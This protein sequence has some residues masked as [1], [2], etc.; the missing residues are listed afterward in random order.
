MKSTLVMLGATVLTLSCLQPS[1]GAAMCGAAPESDLA[2]PAAT[3][4][5]GRVVATTNASRYTYVQIDTGTAK[6]WA[7]GPAVAVKVGDCVSVAATMPNQNFYSPT[8]KKNFDELY[9][10]EAIKLLGGA[11]TNGAIGTCANGVNAKG[12]DCSGACGKGG[13]CGGGCTNSGAVCACSSKAPAVPAGQPG[14]VAADAA[15]S[16]NAMFKGIQKPAGGKTVAEVW[17]EK[18]TLAGKQVTVQARVV[19]MVPNIMGK[20]FLHLRDGTGRE[21]ANDLVVTTKD[22]VKV[23]SIVT[24]RGILTT[25]KDFGAGYQ[26]DVIVE[27]ATVVAKPD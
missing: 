11:R 14:L 25:H 27:D 4:F 13:L 15:M 17:A 5:S 24:A 23:K 9:F 19:K 18:D 2:E 20:T 7:A 21:G 6:I 3:S 12:A 8:L 10:V 22:E 26:Y 16:A 1:A